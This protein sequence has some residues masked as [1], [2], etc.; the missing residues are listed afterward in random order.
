LDL[1]FL[2]QQ[3]IL[4]LFGKKMKQVLAQIENPVLK[5]VGEGTVKDI[6]SGP[7]VPL[8]VRLWRTAVVLGGLA[9][10]LFFVWGAIDWLMSEGNPEKLKSAKN[11]IVHAVIGMGLLAASFAVAKLAETIFGFDI[12]NIVWP[13][14]K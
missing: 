13:T 7:L 11:K 1:K 8:F 5:D 9:P 12:L 10:L 2:I 4:K 3:N 14:P 6:E